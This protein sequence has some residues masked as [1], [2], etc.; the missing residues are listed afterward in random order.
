MGWSQDMKM[1]R[2]AGQGEMKGSP[3]SGKDPT[4]PTYSDRDRVMDTYYYTGDPRYLRSF[5]GRSKRR[6]S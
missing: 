3:P 2:P 5:R 4:D 1:P 6:K